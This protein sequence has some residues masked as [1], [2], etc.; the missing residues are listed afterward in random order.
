MQIIYVFTYNRI[1]V[2]IQLEQQLGLLSF[3]MFI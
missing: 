1:T 2:Q 3:A